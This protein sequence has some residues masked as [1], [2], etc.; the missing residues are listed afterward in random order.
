MRCIIC[1]LR[2]LQRIPPNKK[3]LDLNLTLLQEQRIAFSYSW[4]GPP[5]NLILFDYK[6]KLN[7]LNGHKMNADLLKGKRFAFLQK[8]SAVLMGSPRKFKQH[9]KSGMW[10]SDLLPRTAT[11]ADDICMVRSM[12]TDQ[13]NHHPGQL[14]MQCGEARFGL[15]STGSW[16]N[17]GLGTENRNLP[18]YIVLTAGRGSS[19]GATL[20][21]SGFLPSNYAGVRLRNGSNPLLNLENPRGL[22]NELQRAGLDAL[23]SLNKTHHRNE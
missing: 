14:Q 11:C 18:G 13:F 16:I 1:S 17:Y 8:E 19:G 7:E 23:Q 22:P 10:F 20:W 6:P 2:N 9:G 4:L 5:H 15:P 3:I 12:H 21:Q